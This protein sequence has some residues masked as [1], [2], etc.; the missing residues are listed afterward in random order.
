MEIAAA[1][2]EEARKVAEQAQQDA[3]AA[4]AQAEDDSAV[5]LA[6]KAADLARDVLERRRV[7]RSLSPTSISEME[8]FETVNSVEQAQ[9]RLESAQQE[10][11]LAGLRSQSKQ[12][13]SDQ[14]KASLQRLMLQLDQARGTQETEQLSLANLRTALP[15]RRGKAA[16]ATAESPV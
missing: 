14:Q 15:D 3:A 12:A 8:W 2:V 6:E 7:S 9:I 5:R 1:A 11:K 10:Q 13:A 4:R 16:A